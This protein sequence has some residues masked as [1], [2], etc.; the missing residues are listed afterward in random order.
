MRL[1]FLAA[2]TAQVV[3]CLHA[4]PAL[5][6]VVAECHRLAAARADPYNS[7]GMAKHKQDLLATCEQAIALDS[8]GADTQAALGRAYSSNRRQEDAVKLYRAA[9]AQDHPKAWLE[10]YE[11]HRSWERGEPGRPQLVDRAEAERAL[12]RPPSWASPTPS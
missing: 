1:I 3:A 12:R 6:P 2:A 8:D 9:A 10:L 4:Q 11:R 5:P 7:E